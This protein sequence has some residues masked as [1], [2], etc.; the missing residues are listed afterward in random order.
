M[1]I[2]DLSS[3][4]SNS[5]YSLCVPLPLLLHISWQLLVALLGIYSIGFGYSSTCLLYD[6]GNT[7]KADKGITSYTYIYA[8]T[9]IVAGVVLFVWL[10]FCR[11][12]KDPMIHCV[13]YSVTYTI[14]ISLSLLY[15][16]FSLP[17]LSLS[18]SSS[19]SLSSCFSAL[20]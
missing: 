6:N 15:L 5:S 7:L 12:I 2:H 11:N 8:Y 16:L 9:L 10:S 3:S 14:A 18:L 13:F 1:Y 20:L 4:R 19:T 17:I